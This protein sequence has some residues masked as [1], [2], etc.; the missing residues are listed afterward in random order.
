M[1][2]IY[3]IETTEEIGYDEY[4]SCVVIAKNESE[5]LKIS[6]KECRIYSGTIKLVGKANKSQEYGLLIASFNAG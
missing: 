1:K 5:A 4:D 6:E 3:L 2:N